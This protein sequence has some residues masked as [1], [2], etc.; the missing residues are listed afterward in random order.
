M[1]W[2]HQTTISING[3]VYTVTFVPVCHWSKRGVND[4]NTRLW[5]GFVI[6]TP[7]GQKIFYSG[8]TGYCPVFKEIGQMFGP[9]D[10]SILPI[11]AYEPRII[12]KPQHINPE[13]AVIVHRELRSRQSVGVHWGTF[14]LGSEGYFQ[15][16]DD[17]AKAREKHNV[18]DHEFITVC[19]GESVI[20]KKDKPF[21]R[22]AVQP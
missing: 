17:L 8:D 6:E 15:A 16:R 9:F 1:D 7:F 13:E 19:H 5:G 4:L 2:M 10:L 11:G 21:E 20:F 3:R 14:P 12:L 22:S 18:P